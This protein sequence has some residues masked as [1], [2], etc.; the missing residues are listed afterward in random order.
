MAKRDNFS[1]GLPMSTAIMDHDKS[2]TSM[3]SMPGVS[4][5]T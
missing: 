2:S 4:V 1:A 5:S 3:M